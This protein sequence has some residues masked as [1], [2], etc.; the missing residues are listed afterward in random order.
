VQVAY[1]LAVV[2]LVSSVVL[3]PARAQ[4]CGVSSL[5]DLAALTGREVPPAQLQQLLQALPDPEADMLQIQQAARLLGLNLQ[6]V[7]APAAAL[8]VELSGPAIVH[9]R[10]PDHFVALARAS[11]QWVQLVEG[12]RRW[13]EPAALF[14]ERY[15]GHALVLDSPTP[16]EG[17]RLE[18][19]E[20]EHEF[21]VTGLGETVAH[22]FRMR[23]VGAGDL[24]LRVKECPGWDRPEATVGQTVLA[25]GEA[26]TVSVRQMIR[27]S[28]ALMD[29]V[30]LLTNDPAAPVVHL[31]IHGSVPHNLTIRPESLS[32]VLTRNSPAS[33]LLRLTGPADTAVTGAASVEGGFTAEVAPADTHG[34]GA[35]AWNVRLVFSAALPAGTLV[36]ELRIETTHAARPVVTV[37]VAIEVQPQIRRIPSRLFYGFAE[38][39]RAIRRT[40]TLYSFDGR[41]FGITGATANAPEAT[42]EFV[43]LA[44]DR[45]EVEVTLT[46]TEPGIVETIVAIATDLPGEER[47]EVPVYADVRPLW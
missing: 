26:T 23:N 25:P 33:R 16:A 11:A 28:G 14:A 8:G 18:C 38:P 39:G 1:R 22:A 31:T 44:D 10:G 30:T 43:Q 32:V 47:I 4:N 2:C 7:L 42:A 37:P 40:L 3:L 19:P 13:V 17:A 12:E 29:T 41:A 24:Q 35:R 46:P 27:K 36:D 9:L 45:W 6:G 15:T 20:F 5:V 34:D 21:A